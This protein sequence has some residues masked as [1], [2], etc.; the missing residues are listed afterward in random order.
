MLTIEVTKDIEELFEAARKDNPAQSDAEILRRALAELHHKQELERRRAWAESL[1]ML[2]IS[3][4]EAHTITDS[5]KELR[6]AVRR[7]EA[8]P[9]TAAEIVADALRDE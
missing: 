6:E 9:M 4:E 2:R 1:P 7:G 5:R 3:D 8:R